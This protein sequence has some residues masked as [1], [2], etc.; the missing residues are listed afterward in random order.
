MTTVELFGFLGL[1]GI[2]LSAIPAV[3]LVFSVGVGV[4]FTVHLCMVS[5]YAHCACGEISMQNIPHLFN[6]FRHS[7]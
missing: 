5:F 7:D 3:T 2:K 4:E 1:A 6:A